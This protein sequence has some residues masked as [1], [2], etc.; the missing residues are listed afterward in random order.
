MNCN[1]VY[2]INMIKD[3]D[4]YKNVVKQLSKYNIQGTH[5]EGI[6]GDNSNYGTLQ[7]YDNVKYIIKKELKDKATGCALSHFKCFNKIY[8]DMI[9]YEFDHALVFEDDV[10]FELVEIWSKFTNIQ[11]IVE[12]APSD[13]DIIKLNC[14]N[15]RAT[16]IAFKNSNFYT[17]NEELNK[18]VFENCNSST[19]SYIINKGAI[20][21]IKKH[22]YKDDVLIID[23][24]IDL[25]LWKLCTT[26]NYKY[27]LFVTND[28]LENNKAGIK[29]SNFIRKKIYLL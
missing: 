29:S 26:Y 1:N 22:F 27:P 10:S 20:E 28:E 7:T 19:L 16:E 3:V 6:I 17:N 25:I 8:D 18:K 23:D 9:K 5:I 13:W 11:K 14:S 24:V 21:K 12:D 2:F 4:R 15:R